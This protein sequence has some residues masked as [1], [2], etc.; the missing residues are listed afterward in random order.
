MTIVQ[1]GQVPTYSP[2]PAVTL[3]NY[4]DLDR[5]RFL[6]NGSQFIKARLASSRAS[7]AYVGVSPSGTT[8]TEYKT[9]DGK[10][11]LVN[12][13]NYVPVATGSPTEASAQAVV[14]GF[15][16]LVT[17]TSIVFWGTS[18]LDY[19]DSFK[20]EYS[21]DGSSFFNI[22]GV[23]SD[24]AWDAT[25]RLYEGEEP[26]TGQYK[27]TV[28]LGSSYT[29]KYFRLSTYHTAA[30][31]S[32][33]ADAATT[34]TV[35]STTNFPSSWAESIGMTFTG[36]KNGG[37]NVTR[38]ITYT[39]K[40]SNTFTGVVVSSGI[41][42]SVVVDSSSKVVMVPGF[43]ADVTEIDVLGTYEPIMEVWDTDG[44]Q[45]SS[46]TLS[47]T[48]NYDLCFDSYSDVYFS[49]RL[50]ESYDGSGG[51]GFS[52]S[53]DFTYSV[54]TLNTTRWTEHSVEENFQVNTVSGTLDYSN[55]S[56][57]GSVITNYYLDGDFT[58]DTHFYVYKLDSSDGVFQMRAVDLS[59][60][61]MFVQVGYRGSFP[62]GDWEAVQARNTVNTTAGAAEINNLRVDTKYLN[63][64]EVFTFI[65]DSSSDVWN[66]STDLSTVYSDV[67]PGASYSEKALSMSIVH[68]QTPLNGAQ[69]VYS[70]N[71]QSI[72]GPP[73]ATCEW[74]RL[75]LEKSGSN[76]VCR[77]DD[78]TSGT[79][80]DWVTYTDSDDLNFNI[81]LYANGRS[82]TTSVFLNDYTVSGTEYFSGVPVF[83]IEA[84]NS[85]G[86][87][88]EVS[89]LTDSDGYL[90]KKFDVVND[91]LTYNSFIGDRVQIATDSLSSGAIYV[92]V[93]DDLYKY[94]KSS[95]PLDLEDGTTASVFKESV[96]PETS[97]KSFSY[98]AYS[99]AGLCYVEYDAERS[100]TYLKTISITS[101][102]GTEYESF[103][104]VPSSSFPFGWDQNNNTTFYYVDGT[105]L[106]EYDMDEYDVAFCNVVSEEKI[107]SAGTSTTSNIVATVLN[108]YGEPLSSKTVA[109]AV[110]SGDGA[111][112]GSPTCTNSSGVASAVYTVGT[113]VGTTT[114]TA[115][116]SDVSC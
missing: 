108:V 64:S 101:M 78:D 36:L 68:S 40:T 104:D 57:P 67:T 34:M 44:S 14:V 30:L 107:M 60:S 41:G 45:A 61:N 4:S 53:D 7:H 66:V 56:A 18:L 109:I 43:A 71:R 76:I 73:G 20:I 81:E 17:T 49:I 9:G 50:N 13:V 23:T 12:G 85:A 105:T 90:I 25:A 93:K 52:L 8:Y 26:P 55:S 74:W 98:N 19:Y 3:V 58:A 31:G 111:I 88:V 28:S 87:P 92:K 27:Y 6:F 32:T 65:Y 47:N 33:F 97:A 95:L 38:S 110:S 79:F 82:S 75:G 51:I 22:A 42:D 91:T 37:G 99:K 113:T 72:S 24:W 114:I 39:G 102:S 70:M 46:Q 83:S 21:Y 94:N 116:A 29:A 115:T 11:A 112:S 62:G 89:G 86:D 96:I 59:T 2:D 69:I 10:Y 63:A 106:K 80:V 15:P 5:T 103:L 35:D 77:Y 1:P 100:G 84:L 16:V 48:Y 54:A